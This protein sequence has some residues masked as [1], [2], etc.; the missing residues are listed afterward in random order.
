[1]DEIPRPLIAT[2]FWVGLF[3]GCLQALVLTLAL[4]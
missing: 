2:S 1:V 4:P 3:L